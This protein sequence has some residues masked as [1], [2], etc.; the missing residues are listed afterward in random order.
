MVP[1]CGC[2]WLF[3][4]GNVGVKMRWPF[5]VLLPVKVVMVASVSI[6]SKWL[7]PRQLPNFCLQKSNLYMWWGP[8]RRGHPWMTPIPKDLHWHTG[9]KA[10]FQCFGSLWDCN[11]S[12]LTSHRRHYLSRAGQHQQSQI[13]MHYMGTNKIMEYFKRM[14]ISWQNQGLTGTL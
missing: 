9:I 4:K 11:P 8:T 10:D 2:R 13:N 14:V 6:F 1:K 7:V 3:T 12:A 5:N